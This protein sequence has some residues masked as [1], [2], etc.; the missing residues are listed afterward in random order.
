[1]AQLNPYIFFA[2]NCREAMTFYQEC[3]G[4]EL[5]IQTVGE[6]PMASQ[7][8]PEAHNGVLHSVLQG[9]GMSIMASDNLDGSKLDVGTAIT[10]CINSGTKDETRAYFEKLSTGGTVTG[11]LKDEF[12]GMFGTVTDKFGVNWMFQAQ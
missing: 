11:P 2:G 1:V 5:F 4:G 9:G 6:S 10:L 7:M 8:P 3:L 12:F